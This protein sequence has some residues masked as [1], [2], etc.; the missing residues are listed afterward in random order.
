MAKLGK[1]EKLL[2]GGIICLVLILVVHLLIF[3]PIIKNYNEKRA[4]YEADKQKFDNVMR[5]QTNPDFIKKMEDINKEYDQAFKQ[6]IT[7][8]KIDYEGINTSI[9]G[10]IEEIKKLQEREKETS[11]IQ[12]NI[13]KYWQLP[14][15]LN[16]KL[17]SAEVK[18]SLRRAKDTFPLIDKTE[19][20]IDKQRLINEFLAAL[21]NLGFNFNLVSR[22]REPV[23][24]FIK[25]IFA[26]YL[27]K[28]K[29]D[30]AIDLKQIYELLKVEEPD[31]STLFNYVKQFAFLNDFINKAIEANVLSIDGADF[32][33][34]ELVWAKTPTP[35][36]N[37]ATPTPQAAFASEEA[38]MMRMAEGPAQGERGR[39]GEEDMMF[40]FGRFAATPTPM[41]KPP[42]GNV[43]PIRIRARGTN[44]SV[45]SLL[46]MITNRPGTYHLDEVKIIRDT[47]EEGYVFLDCLIIPFSFVNWDVDL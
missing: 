18:D 3:A 36:P 16:S 37:Q 44:R 45:M 29:G 32:F 24:F 4:S 46:Y 38:M 17:T 30:L 23:P 28:N 1:R 33:K 21:N 12:I 15:G 35:D 39:G 13:T 6:S 25:I 8:L 47:K 10:I 42:L 34:W 26:D 27:D 22:L 7:N 20:P 2:A 14:E 31:Q 43:T 5:V 11:K 19:N 41:E 9:P 40:G